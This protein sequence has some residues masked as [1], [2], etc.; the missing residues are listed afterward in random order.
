MNNIKD[1]EEYTNQPIKDKTLLVWSK[2]SGYH[3]LDFGEWECVTRT[4]RIIG[5]GK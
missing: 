1:F 3:F 2:V 5:V 4:T